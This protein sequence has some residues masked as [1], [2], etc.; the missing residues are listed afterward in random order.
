MVAMMDDNDA[1]TDAKA[2]LMHNMYVI[3]ADDDV[4]HRARQYAI[5]TFKKQHNIKSDDIELIAVEADLMNDI[6]MSNFLKIETEYDR[7]RC[8]G[9]H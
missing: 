1:L 2:I 7:E 5:K 9:S 3:Y 8:T 6:D 4:G